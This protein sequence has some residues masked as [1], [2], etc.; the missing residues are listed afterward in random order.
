MLSE[1]VICP[2]LGEGEVA[3]FQSIAKSLKHILNSSFFSMRYSRYVMLRKVEVYR[4]LGWYF[5]IL[6]Y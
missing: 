5:S 3:L 1:Y 4:G 6:Q 2:S